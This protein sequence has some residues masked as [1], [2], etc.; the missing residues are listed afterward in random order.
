MIIPTPKG[1]LLDIR[2]VPRYGLAG[3]AGA[4]G[5]SLLF[6]LN[7]PPVE[8]AANAELIGLLAQALGVPKG[9]VTIVAGERGRRKRVLVEGV[10]VDWANGK[11][12]MRNAN[13]KDPER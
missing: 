1:V 7:A 2:V 13:T 9:A 4:R 3:F 5:E 12:Q 6:R 11:F 10:T 8:G